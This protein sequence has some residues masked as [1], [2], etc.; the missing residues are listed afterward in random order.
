MNISPIKFINFKGKFVDNYSGE[1]GLKKDG[2]WQANSSYEKTLDSYH[3]NSTNKIYF[4]NPMEPISDKI[5]EQAD[6]IVYDNEPNY[7]DIDDISQNYFGTARKNYK[8]DF[9]EVRQYFYRREMGGFAD[10]TEAQYRQWQAAECVRFYDEAGDLRYKKETAEDDIKALN[11]QKADVEKD[12]AITEKELSEQ[13]NILKNINTHIENLEKIK[14]PY[15]ELSS[16]MLASVENEQDMY[17]TSAIKNKSESQDMSE[18]EREKFENSAYYNEGYSEYSYDKSPKASKYE[19]TTLTY[20]EINSKENKGFRISQA[21]DNIKE[22][23]EK[24]L[25]T[26]TYFV[27]L[28]AICAAT[29]NEMK[30]HISDLQSK[31]IN[32]DNAV[33][34][35]KSF[36]E[37]SKAKLIPLF[38]ELKNFYAKHGLKGLKK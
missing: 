20:A 26:S 32:I 5:K 28:S 14:K 34:N 30:T 37:D 11:S 19:N 35:K 29:I 9:E 23:Q 13:E 7:P 27:G 36:I 17:E 8:K 24:L 25:E 3:A 2:L 4:A 10:K 1:N 22:Q 33:K 6:Y 31:I 38:D 15:E 21:M 18:E 12:L 16:I